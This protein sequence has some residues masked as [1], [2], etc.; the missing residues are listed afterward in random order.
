MKKLIKKLLNLLGLELKRRRRNQA[1]LDR[2]NHEAAL[3][4]DFVNK[5]RWL[6]E[7][8][9]QSV[10][11]IGANH[12]QFASKARLFSPTPKFIPLNRY[13]PCLRN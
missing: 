9:I 6:I 3:K 1:E 5:N 11:D 2:Q 10:L 4:R 7:K 13:L 12:G 8:K